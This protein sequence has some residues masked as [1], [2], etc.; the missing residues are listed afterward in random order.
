LRRESDGRLVAKCTKY[1]QFTAFDRRRKPVN[2]SRSAGWGMCLGL[3][4]LLGQPAVPAATFVYQLP[5]ALQ[6]T[7]EA[8]PTQA[9]IT[10]AGQPN[11]GYQIEASEDLRRWISLENE[12]TLNGE[13][14]FTYTDGRGLSKCFYRVLLPSLP[15]GPNDLTASVLSN[16][17]VQLAWTDHPNN[18]DG[19]SIERSDNGCYFFTQIATMGANVASY[20]DT[21][22]DPGTTYWYRVRAFNVFGDSIPSNTA[23]VTTSGQAA[24]TQTFVSVGSLDGRV[25]EFPETSNTGAFAFPNETNFEALRAGDYDFDLQHKSIL[26]FDTSSIPDGATIVSAT[27]RLR[28]GT[29]VDTN[30]FTTHG[31]C[32][33][34]VKGGAGFGGSTSLA[35]GDFQAAA[36]ATEV[37]SLSNA[38]S[39]G[40]WSSGAL[41]ATG[42]AF[43]DKTGTTQF[44][45]YFSRDDDDDGASDYIGWHSGDDAVA[46]NRPVLEIVYH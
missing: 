31:T 27:L 13:G 4:V 15:V 9:V 5:D 28:R 45:I 3:L 35:T 30:P 24:T 39:D 16:G 21:G 37:G 33:I 34:D 32:F 1:E 17:A 11:V 46:G 18:E 40:D 23:E 6:V 10:L 7:V 44:R 41:E 29:V 8:G 2:Q 22:L 36:D 43:I 25:T 42:L 14:T 12:A 19:F 26:S 38:P 20:V